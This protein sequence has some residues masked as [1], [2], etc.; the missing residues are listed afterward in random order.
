MFTTVFDISFGEAFDN[1][2]NALPINENITSQ[3][4]TA[5]GRNPYNVK[6]NIGFYEKKKSQQL[7]SLQ[8]NQA[9]SSGDIID[10]SNSYTKRKQTLGTLPTFYDISKGPHSGTLANITTITTETAL[11]EN[12]RLEETEEKNVRKILC[13]DDRGVPQGPNG[14]TRYDVFYMDSRNLDVS[15]APNFGSLNAIIGGPAPKDKDIINSGSKFVGSIST[16][17]LSTD[18][19]AGQPVCLDVNASGPITAKA[20]DAGT[21][22]QNILGIAIETKSANEDVDI[23]T[24]GYIT[25]KRETLFSSGNTPGTVPMEG[26]RIAQSSSAY[27]A[28]TSSVAWNYMFDSSPPATWHR[29]NNGSVKRTTKDPNVVNGDPIVVTGPINFQDDNLASDGNTNPG[30]YSRSVNAREEFDAGEG[31][32]F[33][34]KV[35]KAIFEI[36]ASGRADPRYDYLRIQYSD[37]NINYKNLN[38]RVAPNISPYLYY[39][40]DDV[41]NANIAFSTATTILGG[42]GIDDPN[43]EPDDN[44]GEP[45]DGSGP[46]LG[47]DNRRDRNGFDEGSYFPVNI[48]GKPD[49]AG[50]S[51]PEAD[52]TSPLLQWNPINARYLRFIFRSDGSGQDTGFDIDLNVNRSAPAGPELE[53]DSNQIGAPLYLNN[54]NYSEVTENDDKGN[55]LIGYVA[56]TDVSDNSIYMRTLNFPQSS[57][58]F[59]RIVTT[60]PTSSGIMGEIIFNTTNNKMYIWNGSAWR[61]IATSAS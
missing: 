59:S 19:S 56:G 53:L 7:F 27:G 39:V 22:I 33:L 5:L 11:I 52:T 28:S 16:Y 13:I 20:C 47:T 42:S 60:V 43:W 49:G 36:G 24:S 8:S 31:N 44:D 34:M 9:I 29:Q 41:F 51:G 48:G 10:I 32:T 15:G 58:S 14:E 50:T 54:N 38:Q 35:N 55:V 61:A 18:I 23:L 12:L 4:A 57:G 45:W 30:D 1:S 25:A 46:A 37:D 6:T 21:L 40:K 17:T 3:R 26:V 2:N